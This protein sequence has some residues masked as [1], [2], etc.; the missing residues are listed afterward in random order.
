MGLDLTGPNPEIGSGH[1]AALGP[2]LRSGPVVSAEG[3]GPVKSG[4]SAG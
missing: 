1:F 2:D 3:S 4:P